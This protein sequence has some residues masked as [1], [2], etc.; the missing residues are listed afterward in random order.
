M[1]CLV[2]SVGDRNRSTREGTDLRTGSPVGLL[3]ILSSL[4]GIP[5]LIYG[6]ELPRDAIQFAEAGKSDPG[7]DDADRG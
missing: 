4:K 5:W 7:S 6:N 2:V 3:R 1:S